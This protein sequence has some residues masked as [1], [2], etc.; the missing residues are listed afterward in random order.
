MSK[1][2]VSL[3]KDRLWIARAVDLGPS[4]GPHQLSLLQH[5]IL[6]GSTRGRD[7]NQALCGGRRDPGL[8]AV[9]GGTEI[10]VE[11]RR[12]DGQDEGLAPDGSTES[13]EMSRNGREEATTDAPSLG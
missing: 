13:C 9:G 12:A 8:V 3:I 4:S 2:T 10:L 5:D 1:C 7:I 6:L 11:Q